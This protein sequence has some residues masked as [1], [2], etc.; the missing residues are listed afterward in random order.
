MM[1][2]YYDEIIDEQE[3]YDQLKKK[4]NEMKKKRTL[5]E[6]NAITMQNKLKVLQSEEAKATK[7]KSNIITS[8]K[9]AYR[10]VKS[11]TKQIMNS[12][13]LKKEQIEEIELKAKRIES[14]REDLH[15]SAKQYKQNLAEKNKEEAQK[16]L[17]IKKELAIQR[18]NELQTTL[19]KNIWKAM[20]IRKTHAIAMKKR[21]RFDLQKK[22]NLKQTI[23]NELKVEFHEQNKLLV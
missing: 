11:A 15:K 17:E 18:D 8:K 6:K 4:Y 14:I 16:F 5:L 19:D 2:S 1:K 10:L 20:R 7:P 23:L 12:S 22:K 9:K 21:K 13:F 3:D